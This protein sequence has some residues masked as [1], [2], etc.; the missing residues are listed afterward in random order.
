VSTEFEQ[1]YL[2]EPVDAKLSLE[3]RLALEY[4]ITCDAYDRAIC[5]AKDKHGEST[6][7]NRHELALVERHSRETFRTLVAEH[8]EVSPPRLWGRINY[9]GTRYTEK[10]IAEMRQRITGEE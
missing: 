3:D 9:Y 2:A 5:S 1:Q 8:R 10:A 7:A 6:P 4:H